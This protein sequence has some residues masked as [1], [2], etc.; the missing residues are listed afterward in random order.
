MNEL[1]ISSI[2][3]CDDDSQFRKRLSRSLR[4]RNLKVFEAETAEDAVSVA[5]EYQP[6]CA[7]VDMRMPGRG[8]LWG[9]QQL[10]HRNPSMRIVVLTGFGTITSAIDAVKHGAVNYLTKPISVDSLLRAFC[11]EQKASQNTS[12][13]APLEVMQDEY[14]KRVVT[15]LGGNITRAAKALGLHRRSLQRMLRAGDSSKG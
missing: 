5:A 11:T 14:V 12:E 15:E 3:V 1:E 10:L 2:L 6:D 7:I 9:V 13:I 4:E 8:G